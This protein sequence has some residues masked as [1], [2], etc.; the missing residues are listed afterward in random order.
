MYILV[1]SVFAVEGKEYTPATVSTTEQSH[2]LDVCV[3]LALRL[4]CF[5]LE[6]VFY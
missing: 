6:A 1:N 3:R 5:V 4:R 2:C